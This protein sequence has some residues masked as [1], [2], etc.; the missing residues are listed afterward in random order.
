MEIVE[1][2]AEKNRHFLVN[3]LMSPETGILIPLIILCAVTTSANPNFLTVRNFGVILS[4]ATFMGI[5]AIGQGVVIMSG[6]I[7]LSVGLNACFSGIVFGYCTVKLGLHPVVCILAGICAG[8][9]IGFLNGYLVAKFGLVNFV[10]TLASMFLCQGLAITISGGR[11]I[12]PFPMY[13][14]HYS[15]AKPLSLSWSFFIFLGIFIIMEI[16]IRFTTLG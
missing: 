7:D 4:F 5:M 10:T 8:G 9:L 13:Y 3:L 15:L 2:T 1:K 11:P 16:V 12:V 14:L 6:E